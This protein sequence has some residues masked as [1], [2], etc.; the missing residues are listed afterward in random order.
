MI[1]KLSANRFLNDFRMIDYGSETFKP[2]HAEQLFKEATRWL[3]D[4]LSEE[5]DGKTVVVTHHGM[6]SY[7][8]NPKFPIDE[9][10]GCFWSDLESFFFDYPMNVWIFGHTHHSVFEE[11]NGVKVVSNQRGYCSDYRKEETGFISDYVVEI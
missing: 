1:G 8:Q 10:S 2:D 6:C 3:K 7:S 5:Y 4:K 11:I 9:V